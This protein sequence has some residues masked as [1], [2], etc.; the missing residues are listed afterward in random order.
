[1]AVW[2]GE[3]ASQERISDPFT[4]LGAQGDEGDEPGEDPDVGGGRDDGAFVDLFADPGND[5]ELGL[6]VDRRHRCQGKVCLH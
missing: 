5:E 2:V 1:M 3:E 6:L 4:G